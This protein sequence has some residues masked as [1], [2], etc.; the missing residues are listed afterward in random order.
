MKIEIEKQ[1][2]HYRADCKDLPGL[3]P[4]GLGRTPELAVACLLWRLIF[5][6]TGGEGTLPWSLLLRRDEPIT[7]NGEEWA[8]PE[9][10]RRG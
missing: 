2:D 10:Y 4:A 6:K 7:V 5:E 3:P 1:S 9:S 8:W